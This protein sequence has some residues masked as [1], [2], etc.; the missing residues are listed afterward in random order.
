MDGYACMQLIT[1]AMGNID[2][3]D[4]NPWHDPSIGEEH[5]NEFYDSKDG[6]GGCARIWIHAR[7]WEPASFVYLMH[8]VPGSTCFC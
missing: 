3:N 7:T 4:S 6:G 1:E 5:N 8:Q 2:I